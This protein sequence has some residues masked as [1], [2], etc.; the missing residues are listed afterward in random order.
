[1]NGNAELP[2]VELV[3]LQELRALVVGAAPLQARP[4]LL[5]VRALRQASLRA[6]PRMPADEVELLLARRV[7]HGLAQ[8]A[9]QRVAIRERTPAPGA[10]RDPGAVLVDAREDAPTNSR[11]SDA[12]RCVEGGRRASSR[13]CGRGG[14]DGAH[15][16][17][18]RCPRAGRSTRRRA[19]A[20]SRGSARAPPLRPGRPARRQCRPTD[21]IFG[22]CSPSR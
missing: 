11:R 4:A 6:E 9:L 15:A 12:L 20:R 16:S 13:S 8:R 17:G 19:P 3:E 22:A 5:R 1:M 2:L 10:L 21:I 14:T 7:R 18:A